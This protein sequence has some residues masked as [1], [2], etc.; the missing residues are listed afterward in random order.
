MCLYVQKMKLYIAKLGNLSVEFLKELAIDIIFNLLSSLY[1]EFVLNYNM[2]TLN[3]ILTKFH[4]ILKTI[5]AISAKTK[6]SYLV[7]P[8]LSIEHR[9]ANK[10]NMFSYVKAKTKVGSSN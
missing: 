9:D 8:F 3:K 6:S 10:K 2:N 4:S 5:E 7:A 1:H